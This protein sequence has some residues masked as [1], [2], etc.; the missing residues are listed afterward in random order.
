VGAYDDNNFPVDAATGELNMTPLAAALDWIRR[1]FSPVP[2]QHQ[3]KK[4]VLDRWQHLEITSDLAPKYFNGHR[5]NIGVHLGDKYGSTDVDCDCPEAVAA[6]RGLLPETGMIFGRDSKPFSHYIYRSDPPITTEQFRDPVGGA[7]LIELRG[8]SKDG[9]IGLQ[10]V[11]PPSTHVEGELIR[12]EDGFGGEPANIDADVLVVSVRRVAA[13]ALFASHWPKQGSRHDAFLA[14]AGVLARSSWSLEDARTFHRALYCCLWPTDPDLAAADA[15]V[16]STF[17]RHQAGSEV[18]GIPTLLGFLDKKIV[19]AGLRWLAIDRDQRLDVLKQELEHD[20][21][22]Q[23]SVEKTPQVAQ[24][25][26]QDLPR[27]DL[28]GYLPNDHGNAL[29]LVTMYGDD[30]RY[31]H[32]MKKWLVW[33]GMRW[34]VDDTEQA[35]RLGKHTILEFLHQAIA[36][37]A[38]DHAK[39]AVKSLDAPRLANMLR[40]AQCELPVRP[41]ELD[42][43]PFAL[44]FLNGTVDLR[45][46]QLRPYDRA[47]LI[48]KLV[49][50]KY[51]PDAQCPRWNSFITQIMGGGPNASAAATERARQFS[52]HL[53]RALGYSLTGSTKEKKVFVPFGGGDNGKTTMLSTTNIVFEEYSVLLQIETLMTRQEDNNSQADLADLRGARFV[54]TSEAEKGQ[55]LSQG[56]LKRITQG[57]GK[58]KSTRKYENPITFP[59]THKLWLDTNRKPTIKDTDDK[60]TLNRLHPIPFTVTFSEE[61][62]DKG[63]PAKLLT[64]GE[65]ICAWIVEGARLWHTSGLEIP[66]EVETAKAEWRAEMDHVGHFIEEKCVTG[67]WCRVRGAALYSAYQKWGNEAGEKRILSNNDFG[68]VIAARFQKKHSDH[69]AVYLGI[70]L[71]ADPGLTADGT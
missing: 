62:K 58:I 45:T 23:S 65:G 1:G 17:A 69:G 42:T 63:L 56:K 70:G 8:L 49:H 28:V 25:A 6:A 27:V 57:M 26:D 51:S 50:F 61:Q 24:R 64:E 46:G 43:H 3:S 55:T 11:V 41:A 36:A 12:F 14:L 59:E 15:E 34:A 20:E 19:D 67:D 32:A 71:R 22:R 38:S 54:Q 29:R 60:A 7:M 37:G 16:L 47:D 40:L 39:F 13:A 5:Q 52:G 10:T 66:A 68:G 53:Q 44:N 35:C 48:T 4:P 2:V 30:L 31:C 9:S 18:T 21:Y 33:D